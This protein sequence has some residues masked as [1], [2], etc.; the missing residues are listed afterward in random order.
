MQVLI[1]F[2]QEEE[3]VAAPFLFQ[4]AADRR[5]IAP[6]IVHIYEVCSATLRGPRGPQLGAFDLITRE[7]DRN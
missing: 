1:K 6:K 2:S 4:S 7:T 3:E 5:G